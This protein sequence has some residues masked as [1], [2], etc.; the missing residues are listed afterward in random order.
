MKVIIIEDESIALRKIKKLLEEI[1]PSIEIIAGLES[2]FEA[3]KWFDNHSLSEIDLIISDIQLSDGLSF[4]IFENIQIKLPIIFTTAYDEYTL[5]AFKLNGVDY[6]LKPIQKEELRTA[7]EKLKDNIKLYS[8]SHLVDLKSIISQIHHPH[9]KFPT[10]ISYHKDKLIPLSSEDI[11][12]F[13]INNLIV[14]AVIDKI[15]YILDETMDEI[16]KRLPADSFFRANRQFIINKKF[17]ENAEIYFNSRLLIHLTIKTSSEIII[18][19]EKTAL[20]KN[21]LIGQ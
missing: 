8:Q 15:E 10:F 13:Y 1:E 7:I 12:Y 18:S 14:Y 3:K 9:Q 11:A 16:E 2:V 21:W 4:E 20:F 17:I 6:L 5:K 19:R